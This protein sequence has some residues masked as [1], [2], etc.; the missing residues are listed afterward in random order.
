MR[1]INA[2][3]PIRG[4]VMIHV[5]WLCARSRAINVAIR[6]SSLVSD[7]SGG[8]VHEIVHGHTH[9]QTNQVKFCACTCAPVHKTNF[10]IAPNKRRARYF[11]KAKPTYPDSASC[12]LLHQWTPMK[13]DSSANFFLL[14]HIALDSSAHCTKKVGVMCIIPQH[15]CNRQPLAQLYCWKVRIEISVM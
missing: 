1:T 13:Y 14:L 9:V 7:R 4:I 10:L 5:D 3:S 6:L 15:N 2:A 11:V 12:S 8:H